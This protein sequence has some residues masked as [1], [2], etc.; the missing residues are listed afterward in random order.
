[1]A[2]MEE[3]ARQKNFPIIGPACGQLCYLIARLIGARSVFEMGSGYG[4]ST[5][6]FAKAVLENGGG[7]VHHVVWDE[8]L[9][10]Q[11][12]K[13]LRTLGRDEVVRYT[14]G[15]AV[16]ALRS[17]QPPEGG[18]DL[19][20]NDIDKHAYPDSLPVIYEKL[21]RG[22]VLIIDNML[23]DERIF[24]EV[25]QSPDTQGVRAFTQAITADPRWIVSLVPLRDGLIV[26]FKR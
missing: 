17:A 15:E 14:I 9:S 23:W 12:Q 16:A 26:A 20:F 11:A 5:A 13:H 25:D 24:D 21:R 22:G 6:W 8:A 7:I 2:A 19:I 10:Q 3:Y 4:Y 1:M 18:F